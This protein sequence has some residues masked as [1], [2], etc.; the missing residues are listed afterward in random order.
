MATPEQPVVPSVVL[1]PA[2]R[3]QVNMPGFNSPFIQQRKRLRDVS[4]HPAA[5]DGFLVEVF[6]VHDLRRRDDLQ[7][8][9]ERAVADICAVASRETGL[10]SHRIHS[11]KIDTNRLRVSGG[12]DYEYGDFAARLHST[13]AKATLR[14]T[15]GIGAPHIVFIT[16]ELGA[17]VVRNLLYETYGSDEDLDNPASLP[18]SLRP[19]KT[20]FLGAEEREQFQHQTYVTDR[21]RRMSEVEGAVEDQLLRRLSRKLRSVDSQFEKTLHNRRT[22]LADNTW[23]LPAPDLVTLATTI[24]KTANIR[25]DGLGRVNSRARGLLDR[26][27]FRNRHNV[28]PRIADTQ[29]HDPP[30]DAEEKAHDFSQKVLQY[31]SS[32]KNPEQGPSSLDNQL[33]IHRLRTLIRRTNDSI[34]SSIEDSGSGSTPAAVLHAVHNLRSTISNKNIEVEFGPVSAGAEPAGQLSTA[35]GA[36]TSPPV[37]R[38]ESPQPKGDP[39]SH[40]RRSSHVNM[41]QVQTDPAALTVMINDQ[42]APRNGYVPSL[43]RSDSWNP[44]ESSFQ[45][46]HRHQRTKGSKAREDGLGPVDRIILKLN[47]TMADFYKPDSPGSD[48]A[49]FYRYCLAL[50]KGLPANDNAV[51]A[52]NYRFETRRALLDSRDGTYRDR[53]A[54]DHLTRLLKEIGNQPELVSVQREVKYHLAVVLTRLGEYKEALHSLT[55]MQQESWFQSTE[56]LLSSTEAIEPTRFD[57]PMIDVVI[58][59]NRVLA[60]ISGHHAQFKVASECIERAANQ[61]S[62][63]LLARHRGWGESQWLGLDS[64][65]GT[66]AHIPPGPVLASTDPW[67]LPSGTDLE[68]KKPANLALPQIPLSPSVLSIEI[69]LAQ[70]TI[71]MLQG[72][73]AAALTIISP[74]LRRLETNARFGRQHILTLQAASLHSLI[75]CRMGDPEAETT[76]NTT[77]EASMHYLGE[78]HPLVME[79]LS[80][81]AD[82]L[83]GRSRLFEA[84]DTVYYLRARAQK[85]LGSQH[86]QTM[87]YWFQTGEVNFSVGNYAKAR[88]EFQALYMIASK[89]WGGETSPDPK[90]GWGRHPDLARCLARLAMVNCW[91]ENVKDAE[92]QAYKALRWQLEIFLPRFE[93]GEEGLKPTLDRLVSQLECQEVGVEADSPHPHLLES[94]DVCSVVVERGNPADGGKL[95][96]RALTVVWKGWASRYTDTHF[97]TLWAKLQLAFS[98]LERYGPEHDEVAELFERICIDCEDSLGTNHGYTW[99]ARLGR[100]FTSTI[101]DVEQERAKFRREASVIMNKQAEL[102][103]ECHPIVVDSRWRLFVFKLFVYHDEDAHETGAR[104]LE[105]L[106]LRE[107]RRERLMESLLFEERIATIY[108]VELADCERGLPIINDILEYCYEEP[109]EEESWGPFSLKICGL[110][111]RAASTAYEEFEKSSTDQ[112]NDA[113]LL[114]IHT[115]RKLAEELGKTYGGNV[116]IRIAGL[117]VLGRLL[118]QV[119]HART[120][121]DS[122]NWLSSKM[123]SA[124]EKWKH[125]LAMSEI[126]PEGLAGQ[127]QVSPSSK[128]KGKG[129]SRGKRKGERKERNRTERE[130]S[131]LALESIDSRDDSVGPW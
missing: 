58:N 2:Q 98:R 55:T 102:L 93:I 19:A 110:L 122:S 101:G 41:P 73:E 35:S 66:P 59:T 50:L 115:F 62:N 121:Y 97:E 3:R 56:Q 20:I 104:L 80:T 67:A 17:W 16:Y 111:A 9:L 85:D 53:M 127:E 79:V 11:Y 43:L 10:E 14:G 131:E 27:A 114:A 77:L 83:L 129:K 117:I 12:F 103:G 84:L 29:A 22:A 5:A 25:E 60:L 113:A 100:L 128:A 95:R 70:S 1:P 91:L 34:P 52:L 90:E 69:K 105:L 124:F 46:K 48:T 126:D 26:L 99:W 39:A 15:G 108:A 38:T 6:I 7:E 8:K 28:M 89:R 94:L 87:R 51:K 4:K 74:V 120:E 47:N 88:S 57:D 32:T 45:N 64:P 49:A 24:A 86:P 63:F 118:Q 106:R 61:C 36:A 107:I 30:A 21:L 54:K 78:D 65:P 18:L 31:L 119:V 109:W 75:L 68:Y 42:M 96:D 116:R 130:D 92:E 23:I 40:G 72:L 82:V 44:P 81:L 33:Y 123:D 13:L 125:S 112:N 76:C 37:Q 71:L